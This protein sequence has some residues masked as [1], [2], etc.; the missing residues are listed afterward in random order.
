[1]IELVI[2]GGIILAVC[3]VAWF[4]LR[5]KT[6]RPVTKS[7]RKTT[8]RPGKKRVSDAPTNRDMKIEK[9]G[10]SIIRCTDRRKR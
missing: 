6:I 2:F 3:L 8:D 7:R 4:I 9:I 1:M 5:P 10:E